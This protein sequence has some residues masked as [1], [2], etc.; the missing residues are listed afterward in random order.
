M[1]KEQAEWY[2]QYINRRSLGMPY[3]DFKPLLMMY[4]DIL[5]LDIDVDNFMTS[6]G[7]I[8]RITKIETKLDKIYETSA[9]QQ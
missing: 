2:R 9:L 5:G 7:L 8:H 6:N 1:N 4:K 3:S